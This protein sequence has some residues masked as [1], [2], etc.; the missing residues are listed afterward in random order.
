MPLVLNVDDDEIARYAKTRI[1]MRS[2]LRVIE[3]SNGEDALRRARDDQPD[4]VVLDVRLPDLSGLEV[5]RR[6]KADPAT[7]GILVLQTSASKVSSEDRVRG[8]EGGADH[9]LAQPFEPDELVATT[10]ALLRIREAESAMRDAMRSAQTTAEQLSTQNQRLELLSQVA[11]DLLAATEMQD[12]LTRLF[13]RIA[14]LLGL[15]VYFHYLQ[16]PDGSLRLAASGGVEPQ[17]VQAGALL[18]EGHAVCGRAAQSGVP[19]H[20]RRILHSDDPHTAFLRA[21][22][23]QSYV[24]TPMRTA[25]RVVGTLGFGRRSDVDFVDD[26]VNFLRTLTSYVALARERIEAAAKIGEQANDLLEADRRKDEFLAILAHELRN[27]LAPIRNAAHVLRQLYRDDPQLERWRGTIERQAR[28][29]ARLVDDLLDVARI[30]R[31]KIVLRRE[32]VRLGICVAGAIESATPLIEARRHRLVVEQFDDALEVIGDPTRLSQMVANLLTNAAKYTPDGGSIRVRVDREDDQG[33]I[34]VRDDGIGLAPE[35]ASRL[36]ELFAQAEQTLDRAQGGLGVGLALTRRLVEMHGG[37]VSATSEG[38]GRGSEF[39]LRLPLAPTPLSGDTAEALLPVAGGESIVDVRVLLVEDNVD[40]AQSTRE[41]L[42]LEG[43]Q[44]LLAGSATEALERVDAF[45]P[46]VVFVDVGLP[47]MTG[48]ELARRLRASSSASDAAIIALTGY[49][50][51]DDLRESALAGCDA[52]LVK[53]VD[54]ERLL[55]TIRT[56]VQR[57]RATRVRLGR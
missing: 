13:A 3:T 50:Q 53:P 21:C 27:P 35:I 33:V 34:R 11:V 47:G 24:C 9:Y 14:P 7:A 31:G 49:G 44:V 8:L 32:R 38:E 19:Q 36:F 41:L 29:M 57:R 30:S 46:D 43:M 6:L 42:E 2:G 51:A 26:E 37:S 52:H 40:A 10:R 23:L 54:P 4:I 22:G 1:L 16:Q 20:A 45:A 18:P 28:Q 15:D 25:E 39:T 17:L 12:L 48:Y 55:Q 56:L 5:C